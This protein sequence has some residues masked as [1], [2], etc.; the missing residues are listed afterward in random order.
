MAKEADAAHHEFAVTKDTAQN[1]PTGTVKLVEDGE[2]VL[3]PT[4]SPDPRG[5]VHIQLFLQ[6][7]LLTIMRSSQPT[8]MAEVGCKQ[9]FRGL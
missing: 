6:P 2:I 5:K 8:S 3:I 4:P 1:V 9:H 7:S